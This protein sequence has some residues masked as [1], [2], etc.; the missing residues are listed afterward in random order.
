MTSPLPAEQN[1]PRRRGRPR[2]VRPEEVACAQAADPA[3][4]MGEEQAALLRAQSVIDGGTPAPGGIPSKEECPHAEEKPS[5]FASAR[6]APKDS[7]I[8]RA[9]CR[10][11]V[12]A[13]V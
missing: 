4:G 8:G 2:K 5:A 9:S 7:Q 12:F 10:E 3:S 1:A 11:R 13:V 6:R